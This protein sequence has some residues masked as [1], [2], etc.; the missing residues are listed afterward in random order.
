MESCLKRLE[1]SVKKLDQMSNKEKE[2][3]QSREKSMILYRKIK[4]VNNLI[5]IKTK[6]LEMLP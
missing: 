5:I 2:R 6:Y 4:R 1:E 3:F